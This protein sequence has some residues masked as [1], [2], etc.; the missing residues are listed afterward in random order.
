MGADLVDAV[1]L[2]TLRLTLEPLRIDHAEE[3]AP[4]LAERVLYT[5]TGGVPPTLEELRARYERQA[6]GR[7]PDGAEAWLNWIVRRRDDG[8]AVG[9]VQAAIAADPPVPAPVTAVLAWVLGVRF[10][11][12]GYAREAAEALAAWLARVGVQRLVAY[13]DAEHAASIA[14]ARALGLGATEERV[15]GEVVWERL[16]GNRSPRVV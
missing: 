2:H 15:D 13:I 7:S 9:F 12:H 14:V 10:Q 3:M 11:G 5:Y 16:I 1:A 8:Q 4:L 6:T